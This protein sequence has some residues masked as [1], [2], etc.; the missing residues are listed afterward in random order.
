MADTDNVL[1]ADYMIAQKQTS[2]YWQIR[3]RIVDVIVRNSQ[4][5]RS[6]RFIS[7]QVRDGGRGSA[8][9]KSAPPGGG[10]DGLLFVYR[11]RGTKTSATM[12]MSLMRILSAGPEVSLK[13]SPTVSPVTAAL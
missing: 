13:G 4:W 9:K 7:L 1:F 6:K 5:P 2:V 10:A 3:Q 11:N 12:L 8:H